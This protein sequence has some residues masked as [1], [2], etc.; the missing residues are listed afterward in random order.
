MPTGGAGWTRQE[1]RWRVRGRGRLPDVMR[2]RLLIHVIV[3]AC[4]G[5]ALGQDAGPKVG[6]SSSAD[7]ACPALDLLSAAP[8]AAGGFDP[9]MGETIERFVRRI[10]W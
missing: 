4:V 5:L 6:P 9:V 8:E 1:A 2:G 10:P 3:L 7:E